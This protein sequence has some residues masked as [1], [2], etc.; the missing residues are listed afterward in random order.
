MCQ[1]KCGRKENGKEMSEKCNTIAL[2][3]KQMTVQQVPDSHLQFIY[4]YWL[5][6]RLNVYA[7][8][9]FVLN[10]MCFGCVV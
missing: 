1:Q 10:R 9:E 3:I 5:T 4:R 2:L 7:F 8:V 6:L